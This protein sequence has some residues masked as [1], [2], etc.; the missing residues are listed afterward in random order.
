[1]IID[2][3]GHYTTAPPQLRAWRQAQIASIGQ[4]FNETLA[5]SDDEIRET[6]I[7]GQLKLQRE[8]GTDLALFSPTAAGMSVRSAPA[9]S[10]STPPRT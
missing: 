4:P 2:V 9:C 7:A 5:I 8:R 6:V 3:H 10:A 1:M